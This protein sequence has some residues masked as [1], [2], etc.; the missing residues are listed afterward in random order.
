MR[1]STPPLSFWLEDEVFSWHRSDHVNNVVPAGTAHKDTAQV[2]F[3][4][5]AKEGRK[6]ATVK[7][8]VLEVR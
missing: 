3:F 4:T 6:F 7:F 8:V 5:D 2:Q 1:T